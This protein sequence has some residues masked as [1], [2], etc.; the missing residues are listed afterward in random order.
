MAALV[1]QTRPLPRGRGALPAEV[2]QAHQRRRILDAMAHVVSAKGFANVTVS[3]IVTTAGVARKSFYAL[4]GD[5]ADCYRAGYEANSQ[6][7][8]DEVAH[9]MA[10]DGEPVERLLDGWRAYLMTLDRLPV[11]ARAYLLESTRVGAEILDD[12]ERVH[13]SFEALFRAHHERVRAT[14][15]EVPVVS[16]RAIVG[17]VGGVNELVCRELTRG[18][19]AA[20]VMSLEGDVIYLVT[21]VLQLRKFLGTETFLEVERT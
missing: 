21:R 4:F 16:D 6:I 15:R 20:D 11:Y 2:V 9:A 3:D 8:L 7:L 13:R 5:K 12:R 1:D 18:V 14:H 19:D 17:L 10:A